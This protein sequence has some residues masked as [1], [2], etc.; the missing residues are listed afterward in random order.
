MSTQSNNI[1][2]R[3]VNLLGGGDSYIQFNTPQDEQLRIKG[4]LN[5]VDNGS[6]TASLL[7]NGTPVGSG[8]GGSAAGNDTNVQYNASGLFAGSDKF[9]FTAASA[10]LTLGQEATTSTLV[11]PSATT[12]NTAGGALD[13]LAGAGDGTGAGGVL[14]VLAGDSGTTGSCGALNL[15]AGNGNGNTSGGSTNLYAGNGSGTGT[16]G[17][18]LISSGAG[19]VTADSGV[20]IIKSG[21]AGSTSGDSGPIQIYTGGSIAGAT[22]AIILASGSASSGNSGDVSVYTA[23]APF[24][25]GANTGDILLQ[26]GSGNATSNATSGGVTINSGAALGAAGTAG[27][28]AIT[29][30]N[31]DGGAAASVSITSGTSTGSGAAGNLTLKAGSSV[32]GTDG[33]I[34]MIQTDSAGT[35]LT[36]NWPTDT[37]VA[38]ENLTVTSIAAGVVDLEWSAGSGGTPSAPVNSIQY[39][40]AGA[41]GGSSKMTYDDTSATVTLGVEATTSVITAPTATTGNTVGGRL[42]L[43]SGDGVGTG[44]GGALNITSGSSGVTASAAG[45]LTISGGAGTGNA[46]GGTTNLRSGAGSGT[47]SG[48][49]LAVLSGQGGATADGGLMSVVSGAGG[50]TS[51]DSG[52]LFLY[53]G[54]ATSG[55]T[56]AVY[57]G[58]SSNAGGSSGAALLYTGDSTNAT[59]STG[60]FTI[61]TGDITTSTGSVGSINMTA[62]E[63]VNSVVNGGAINITAGDTTLG[64]SGGA[65][66]ISGGSGN[67]DGNGGN[68]SLVPGT[69]LNGTQG[70]VKIG[71]RSGGVDY[72]YNWPVDQPT[73]SDVLSVQ[74]VIGGAVDLSWEVGGGGGTTLPTSSIMTITGGIPNKKYRG[75]EVLDNSATPQG[76]IEY[77]WVKSGTDLFEASAYAT[78]SD[79]GP[80]VPVQPEVL[81]DGTRIVGAANENVTMDTVAVIAYPAVVTTLA[82]T[83]FSDLPDSLNLYYHS[84]GYLGAESAFNNATVEPLDGPYYKSPI[85]PNPIWSGDPATGAIANH[86]YAIPAS[87]TTRLYPNPHREVLQL[88]TFENRFFKKPVSQ[89]VIKGYDNSVVNSTTPTFGGVDATQVDLTNIDIY[90][91]GTA[92]T[93]VFAPSVTKTG[94]TFTS[95]NVQSPLLGSA[96]YMDGAASKIIDNSY[97]L[98]Y[99]GNTCIQNA[100]EE[101]SSRTWYAISKGN[102][103]SF[104]A[105]VLPVVSTGLGTPILPSGVMETTAIS[106]G[107]TVGA[108][109]ITFATILS[110]T[111]KETMLASVT[112]TFPTTA[113]TAWFQDDSYT[114]MVIY[115]C[116]AQGTSINYF[117]V[118]APSG[119]ITNDVYVNELCVDAGT[120]SGGFGGEVNLDK[121]SY[122]LAP[123]EVAGKKKDL[124]ID[125][126]NLSVGSNSTDI[127]HRVWLDD[128]YLTNVE[129]TAVTGDVIMYVPSFEYPM[130]RITGSGNFNFDLTI[131]GTTTSTMTLIRGSRGYISKVGTPFGVGVTSLKNIPFESGD[132]FGLMI[133]DMVADG[134]IEMSTLSIVVSSYTNQSADT[135][136]NNTIAIG[137]DEDTLYYKNII[138]TDYINLTSTNFNVRRNYPDSVMSFNLGE[139]NS[140]YV[141]PGGTFSNFL[142]YTQSSGTTMTLSGGDLNMTAGDLNMTLG[143]ATLTNGNLFMTSGSATLTSGNI[144]LT[145]GNVTLVAGDLT[146]T[147]DLIQNTGTIQSD[148]LVMNKG[149]VTQITSPTTPVTVNEPTGVITTVSFVTIA[150]QNTAFTVTN[151]SCAADSC[152]LLTILNY[153]GTIG[154]AGIPVVSV[155]TVASGSFV[156]NVSNA[157]ATNDLLGVLKI[158]YI[159]L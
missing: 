142:N 111:D 28:I 51:G 159:I 46:I 10:T 53:T 23:D 76:H 33:V 41:F 56:G 9:N 59:G 30:G 149:T 146:V 80:C 126:I 86:D 82:G 14:N 24:S 69:T 18:L 16:G 103:Y 138:G 58:S 42:D 101:S 63:S 5:I 123:A 3:D 158:G 66:T 143:D 92:I 121:I 127:Y 102:D 85:L 134:Y 52:A 67:T 118:T 132:Y 110:Q 25:I 71:A 106:L 129:K 6:E 50:S 70:T 2:G 89:I 131:A 104:T 133:D 79:Y 113:T 130:K 108:N 49:T 72:T 105:A 68:I 47:G 148:G 13:V 109:L 21:T 35:E 45:T 32:S 81:C 107:G 55:G 99:V 4:V 29:G 93:G 96:L 26:S 112:T 120:L 38:A 22:G 100:Y 125:Q 1:Y 119:I 62:G 31:S 43:L 44:A 74:S 157:H 40:N 97:V 152:V 141:D 7:I 78:S 135:T 116:V 27:P 37:P 75:I 128:N 90:S 65:V 20:T 145:S 34:K 83:S 94:M 8:G 98:T 88:N 91:G 19:G 114:T 39:N 122:L 95:G 117:N 87:L 151:S 156:I 73:T 12:L 124:Y 57:L 137:S 153:G 144:T 64:T 11:A 61:Q 77:E 139:P 147:G 115:D 60:S 36:F 84:L 154:T 150:Q 54:A 155:S 15:S 48:G 17:T 140:T 136:T